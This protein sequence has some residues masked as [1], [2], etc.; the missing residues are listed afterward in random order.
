M[1]SSYL[2]Y[3]FINKYIVWYYWNESL[4]KNLTQWGKENDMAFDFQ[5]EFGFWKLTTYNIDSIILQKRIE[6]QL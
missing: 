3:I 5:T 1:M 6:Q 2:T 4:E